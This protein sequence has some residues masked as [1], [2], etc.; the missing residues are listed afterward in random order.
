MNKKIAII[1]AGISGLSCAYL[2]SEKNY[3]VAVFA[4]EFSPNI[5]SNRAA[6]FW[7]PYH[8]RNDK[9]AIKWSK[10]SY[11]FYKSLAGDSLTGISMKQLIKA[12][13][14]KAEEEDT[15]WMEF[16]PEGECKTLP[17]EKLKRGIIRALSTVPVWAHVVYV[18]MNL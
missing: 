11:A 10:E 12:I 4:K 17:E 9:R 1:G 3:S 18:M 15:S 8:V 13:P 7:F 5:T 6:A 2:L 16:I 14:E